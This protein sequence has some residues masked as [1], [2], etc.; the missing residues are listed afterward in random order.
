MKCALTTGS[1]PTLMVS[2]W[3]LP[4]GFASLHLSLTLCRAERTRAVT[5]VFGSLDVGS[6]IGLLV[7]GPLIRTY[8]WASVFY[9]FAA[10]GLLWAAVWPLLK[11]NDPDPSQP[12]APRP[13]AAAA[14]GCDHHFL[15]FPS[16]VV[17]TVPSSMRG[18]CVKLWDMGR[19]RWRYRI[20]STSHFEPLD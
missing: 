4:L 16:Q 6:V 2:L 18:M 13:S 1:A 10:L 20:C 11:P 15:P 17:K 14:G 3:K 19:G 8:G 7:C 12:V 9:I 5:S